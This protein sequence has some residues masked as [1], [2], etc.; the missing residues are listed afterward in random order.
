MQ[1]TKEDQLVEQ[2]IKDYKEGKT[3]TLA[4]IDRARSKNK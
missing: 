2:A 1:L 4:D 3:A